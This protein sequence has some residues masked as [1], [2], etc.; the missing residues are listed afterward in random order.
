M[1]EDA[2]GWIAP[3]QGG[4]EDDTPSKVIK[5][6]GGRHPGASGIRLEPPSP[7]LAMSSCFVQL[8]AHQA[9]ASLLRPVDRHD[10][11][12]H[13][14][15]VTADEIRGQFLKDCIRVCSN[16]LSDRCGISSG[17]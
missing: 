5:M 3:C 6:T 9:V 13:H 16:R 14:A 1:I 8:N 10:P 11:R 15:G 7:A 2:G 4:E 17:G 12:R